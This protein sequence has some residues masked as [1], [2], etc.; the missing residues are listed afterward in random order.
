M[1]SVREAAE[2]LRQIDDVIGVYGPNVGGVLQQKRDMKLVADAYL[3]EHDG[4][5]VRAEIARLAA[6]VAAG[7]RVIEAAIDYMRCF[8]ARE[9][10]AANAK[11]EGDR[12]RVALNEA[13]MG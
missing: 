12:L 9:E 3:R 1:D 10:V 13:D 6:R 8:S 4:P 5:D 2:R 7:E 11:V